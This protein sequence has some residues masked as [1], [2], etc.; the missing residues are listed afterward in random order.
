[1]PDQSLARISTSKL[2]SNKT[3]E[4][5]RW[6]ALFGQMLAILVVH[7]GLGFSLPLTSCLV[8]IVL[9]AAVGL[10]QKSISQKNDNLSLNTV[11]ALLAYDIVQLAM[12]IYLTGGLLNPFAILF[13][14]PITVSATVLPQRHT[15][16]LVTIVVILVSILAVYHNPLPWGDTALNV[17][18][19]YVLGIW[20][21]LVISSIFIAAYAGMISRQSRDLARGLAE[22]RLTMA[23]EQQMVALGSL[24]T[25]AAHK[26]GSPLNTITLIAHEFDNLDPQK[27]Y[28]LI[29]EDLQ[30]LKDETE[31][32]RLILAELNS[33]AVTLGSETDDPMPISALINSLLDERLPDLK[34]IVNLQHQSLDGTNQPMVIW[35]ADL[36]HPLE[37]LID[38]AGQYAKTK[39]D[40]NLEWSMRDIKIEI[41][42][43]GPGILSS[44][45][46]RLGEPYNSSRSGEDGHMGLGV[47]IAKTMIENIGG[48]LTLVNKRG[49]KGAR[50]TIILPR[51]TID[52]A[53]IKGSRSS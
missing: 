7:F 31:R 1:M 39:I 20:S 8:V 49:G 34:S 6:I 2:V 43:D 53:N 50:A 28:N 15:Y 5:I 45:L 40:I 37:T 48:Q 18:K 24:A 11:F 4:N 44:V 25:A 29:K 10:I 46:A 22:A 32:C 33:D 23:K 36:L 19:L 13:L 21:A 41:E 51:D 42:D 52:S 3:L 30:A 35:R 27:D 16:Y 9:S 47:F 38:N 17:P 12:L 26:L 14:A